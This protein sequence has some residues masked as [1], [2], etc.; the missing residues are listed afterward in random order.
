MSL[1]S[2]TYDKNDYFSGPLAKHGDVLFRNGEII[3]PESREWKLVT[4]SVCAPCC[5]FSEYSFTYCD[6]NK[7]RQITNTRLLVQLYDP[8]AEIGFTFPIEENVKLLQKR[9]HEPTAVVLEPSWLKGHICQVVCKEWVVD[10]KF[11]VHHLDH[12]RGHLERDIEREAT[13]ISR[14]IGNNEDVPWINSLNITNRF[15]RLYWWE[16]L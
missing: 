3:T 4:Q 15:P 14:H 16:V 8:E 1:D 11:N 2:I 7:L 12:K 6:L 10:R 9:W 13:F 5:R